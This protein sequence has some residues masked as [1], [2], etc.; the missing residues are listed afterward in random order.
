ML[1]PRCFTCG[2]VLANL[3][4]EYEEGLQQIDNNFKLSSEE[5]SE[6]KKKLINKL[7][8]DRWKNRYCC[9]TRLISYVDLIKVII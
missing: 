9:R 8:P 6:L 1:P 5:K 7:L 3:E 2:H 4:L